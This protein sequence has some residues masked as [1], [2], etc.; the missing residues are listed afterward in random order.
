MQLRNLS[1]YGIP[2]G[3]SMPFSKSL[4]SRISLAAIPS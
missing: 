3:I 1:V 4:R 2:E